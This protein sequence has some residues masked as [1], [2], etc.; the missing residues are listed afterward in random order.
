MQLKFLPLDFDYKDLNG[1]TKILIY[2]KTEDG[3]NVVV[4]DDRY[5]PYFYVLPANVERAKEEIEKALAKKNFKIKRI[6]KERKNLFGKERVFLKISCFRSIDAYKARDIIKELEAER[7]G[8]GSIVDEYEYA[9][10]YYRNYLADQGFGSLEWLLVKGEKVDLNFEA[11]LILKASE[12]KKIEG[13]IPKLTILAFDLEVVEED[14][15]QKVVMV[16]FYG[17]DFRKVITYKQASYP[18]WV[19]VVSSE[20]RLLERF[21]QVVK[22]RDVNLLIGYN[23]D[24][25]DFDVLSTRAEKLN[26]N[27]DLSRDRSGVRFSRRG[28]VST[29]RLKGRVHIDL[30][31]FINNILSPI[32]QTEV[33]TLD[34]VSAELLG[35][36]KIEMEYEEILEAWKKRKDLAKLAEYCLKDSELTYRLAK[37][38]LPQIFE[39]TKIVGQNLF[40]VS[41]MTYSQ[42]VEWY[43][44][45]KAKETNRIIPNQP[46]FDEIRKRRRVSYIG[47]Y[48]K[49]P[50][51]GIHERIAV[52]DF[53]SL[54]PT[55]ISSYNISVNTLNCSCCKGD[56]YKVPNLPHWFCKKKKGFESQIIK[57]LLLRRWKLKEK[58]KKLKRDTREYKILEARSYGLKTIANASYGYYAFPASKWYSKECAESITAIGRKSIKEILKMAKEAGFD[59]IYADTD[60]AFIKMGEK[61][62]EDV[63]DFLD[64]VNEKLPGIMRVDLEAFYQ[65][66]IFIP[67]GAAPGTA[68]KRYALIDEEGNL[69]IR[70]LEKVRRDWSRLAKRTQ[71]KVLKL[72]LGKK[73]VKGAVSYVRKIVQDLR[74]LEVSLKDL[75]IYEQITKPLSEY[76]AMSPHLM[77]AKKLC[78]RGVPVGPGSVIGFVITKGRGKISQRAEPMEFAEVKDIDIDY[79]INNQVLPAALRILQVLGITEK[80]LKT[81]AGLEK[82]L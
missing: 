35:D 41:R 52:I 48:V 65:R 54:Y 8:S 26:V 23:S 17:K 69:K 47:G 46:K 18:Y 43:Y 77:A 60:S 50:K 49:E 40:D 66:G 79:Y 30:F 27:L 74:K 11:D 67:R 38:L 82:F 34:S 71:E 81:P 16:S 44:T 36:E 76:K 75:V 7:G 21:V 10:G 14:G 29:A 58:L 72:V 2:G 22:E 73:D 13:E 25:F 28:R 5:E 51:G 4:I 19:E 56:G 70:G 61:K 24:L 20:K 9:I 45:K 12:I 6:E 63:L 42:L 1:K 59:P 53:A 39:L 32:L 15:E 64:E 78:E 68:K 55:I 33:L 31:N 57:D 37:L 80:Q 62:K 3:R